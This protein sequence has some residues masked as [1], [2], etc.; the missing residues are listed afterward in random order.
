MKDSE[1]STSG[2]SFCAMMGSICFRISQAIWPQML[3]YSI[4]SNIL[5]MASLVGLAVVG[6]EMFCGVSL[7][8]ASAAA[9]LSVLRC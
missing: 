6:C 7:G 3:L 1:F 4:V 2:V 9:G 8:S 5:L